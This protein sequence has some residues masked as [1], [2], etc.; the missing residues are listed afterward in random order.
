VNTVIVVDDI[1]DEKY[2]IELDDLCKGELLQ[3]DSETGNHVGEYTGYEWQIVKN[4]IR[5]D[6]RRLRLLKT[7]SHFIGY[8]IPTDN[9]EPMQLFAKKF[10]PSSFIDVHK[11]DPKVYGDWV[12]M[13]YLTDEV[14]GALCTGDMTIIPKRNRLVVMR[15][16]FDHWVESCSGD[17]I[18]ISGWPFA[19]KQVREKWKEKDSITTV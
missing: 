7:V 8:D 17:R 4:T 18:N 16:G 14:D 2:L 1:F 9:L 5:T 6:Q 13:L 3:L 15:T 10:T 12:W 19:T 11:E